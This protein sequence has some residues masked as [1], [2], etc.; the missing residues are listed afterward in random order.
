MITTRM[1]TFTVYGIFSLCLLPLLWGQAPKDETGSGVVFIAAKDG[2][3]QFLDPQGKALPAAKTGVGGTLP[4]GYVAQAGIGGKIVLLLSNGTVMTLES[5]TKLKISEFSQEAFDAAGR[6][7]SDLAEEPSKS[8][9]KLDLDWGSI[10]VATKKLNRESSLNIHS[11]SGVAGIRGTQFQMSQAPGTG[12]KLDV[13]ESTVA[14]SP[15][16][17]GQAVPVGAGQG[18]DVSAAGAVTPRPISPIAAQNI[19]ATNTAAIAATGDVSLSAVSDAMTEATS[20]GGE[21]GED[22]GDG[23]DDSSDGGDEGGDDGGDGGDDSS[24]SG[25]SDSG[26][27]SDSAGGGDA[28]G[29]SGGSG[30]S[31]A[32]SSAPA[33]PAVDTSQVLENNA[34]ATQSR[35]TGKVSTVSKQV[36][37]LGLTD[38]QAEIF[39]SFGVP[40]QSSLAG[41]GGEVAKRLIDLTAQGVAQSHLSTFFGYSGET[42][43]KMLGLTDDSSLANLLFKQY[44]ESWLTGILSDNNLVALN[45]EETPET[46]AVSATADPFLALA[47]TLRDS[48][49]SEVLDELLE[50]G[51]GQL[52]D[53]LLQEG[54]IANRLL[55]SVTSTGSLDETNLVS[56]TDALANRFYEDVTSLYGALVQDSLLAGEASFIGG[57]EISLSGGD[58][59]MSSLALNGSDSFALGATEK[60]QLQGDILFSGDAGS[61]KRVV[62][63][64]G[65]KLEGSS[66]LTLDAATNDL[67]LS[68]RKDIVLQGTSSELQGATAE[69]SVALRGNREVT[70]HSM[71]D[72]NLK[73]VEVTASQ[74]ASIKAA[75]ELYVD[76]MRFN[77]E[78]P[79]I[80]M[81]A[82][83]IRLSNVT[84]P[85][86]AAVNLNSLKGAIDGRYPNFG[87]SVP[88]AQ[89]LGRV[90]FLQNVKSGVNL[91]HDRPSFDSFG[92]KITIG[93]L[94]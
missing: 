64:S 21:G 85:A 61:A 92:G 13:S 74:Q 71:R 44:E 90:N 62:L 79:K 78:L 32:A 52:T 26:G 29:D 4:E 37:R 70:L 19:T 72:V 89:Q 28:G 54:E 55:G 59:S 66:D 8:N 82:T 58:Y 3:T 45:T 31:S 12:V 69:L 81:E 22:G 67:V 20:E 43:A 42:R 34:E 80:V 51:G 46:P 84:F 60:L 30:G 36:S 53:E 87:T 33:A 75:K 88:A 5:Q 10:V 48:G 83:T 76:N 68:V 1:K 16:G 39:Y 38:A 6:K 2:P 23:G 50:L 18:L 11:P 27:D 17:G 41:A 91:L 86:N 56:G 14:F 9:V 47:N 73:N 15:P 49:N 65:D 24:G 77:A 93:K 57:R 25:D 7:V 40:L 63:M 94:R 35:K